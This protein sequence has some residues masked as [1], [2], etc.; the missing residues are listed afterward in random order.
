MVLR[1]GFKRLISLLLIVMMLLTTW[2]YAIPGKEVSA[3]KAKAVPQLNKKS[4]NVLVKKS[5][6]LKLKKK[7][8]GAKIRWKSNKKKVAKVNKK[9]KVT[10]RKKGT[11]QITATVTIKGKRRKL[12][13]KVNVIQKANSIA[14]TYNNG[15]TGKNISLKQGNVLSL[16]VR[17]NP[18]NSNDIISSW[19]SSNSNAVR[20]D[21][22]GKITA[23]KQG[24]AVITAT[25]FGKARATVNVSVLSD[26][27]NNVLPTEVVPT[28]ETPAVPPIETTEPPA[29]SPTITPMGTTEEPPTETPSGTTKEP[30]TET[31]SGT[32]EE[33]ATETPGINETTAEIMVVNDV[34]DSFLELITFGIFHDD[35]QEVQITAESPV[36]IKK[37]EYCITDQD[38]EIGQMDTL[39]FIEYDNNDRPILQKG[40]QNIV[41]AKITDNND[42]VTYIR[43]DGIEI[44]ADGGETSQP[45]ATPGVIATATPGTQASATPGVIST[46]TPTATPGTPGILPLDLTN[47]NNYFAVSGEDT[48]QPNATASW[49]VET[50]AVDVKTHFYHQGIGFKFELPAGKTLADYESFEYD[51]QFS[52]NYLVY[53]KDL[54][55]DVSTTQPITITGEN[56]ADA[57][58][59]TREGQYNEEGSSAGG[60]TA[61]GE[62]RWFTNQTIP[63]D[64]SKHA[65]KSGTIYIAMGLHCGAT[66]GGNA[67]YVKNVRLKEKADSSNDLVVDLTNAG[68]YSEVGDG[69]TAAW[70]SAD[71]GVRAA[72]VDYKQGITF[73]FNI[74]QGK[75]L[76][77]YES[78]LYDIKFDSRYL[79]YYKTL[80]ADVSSSV[81][82]EVT[83]LDVS[84][85]TL[86]V[87]E[88]P[89]NE[90]GSSAAGTEATDIRLWFSNQA[91]PIDAV[92]HAN[93]TG[94]V[95]ITI[96]LHCGPTDGGNAFFVK[97]VRLKAKAEGPVTPPTATPT[98]APTATPVVVPTATPSTQT[99]ATPKVT[100]TATPTATPKI[101]ATL[102]PVQRTT[103]VDFEQYEL[104]KTLG[105]TEGNAS[106]TVK[107]SADPSNTGQKSLQ[108]NSTGHNQAAIVPIFLPYEV[109]SYQTFKFRFRLSSGTM[110]RNKEFSLYISNDTSNFVKYGFG[111][112]TTEQ[113]SF[114]PYLVGKVSAEITAEHQNKWT[115]FTIN[116]SG[117]SD[118]IKDMRGDLFM[119]I[120]AHDSEAMGYLI[121]DLSFDLISSINPTQVPLPTL[122]PSNPPAPTPVPEGQGAARIS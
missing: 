112:P 21:S 72:T 25:M 87:R 22:K 36:G 51:I 5:V 111:N 27:G 41:Y 8:K 84:S 122:R 67:Y 39:T 103:T 33:P 108:I 12:T 40:T 86:G 96:G 99:S 59:G 90:A 61:T 18:S 106:P 121:D 105:F 30:P 20:V 104:D 23:V 37:I 95:Y 98:A 110:P 46:A 56:I 62:R 15:K 118:T 102:P 78:F 93:V 1:K 66:D 119:A 58:L 53:Y 97:N 10:G 76:A 88:N 107:I 100:P 71:N 80:R 109:K 73:K 68:N 74:P 35:E 101:P 52:S 117:L 47:S 85:A 48:S 64:G 79:V 31:P 42:T 69:A 75:T 92:K 83:D 57:T 81:P 7:I 9:G 77:D 2:M 6:K 4:V 113:Y 16:S 32:T 114:V 3:A 14:I 38:V 50:S 45:S 49:S 26:G 44:R 29:E 43:S 115:E 60:T 55:A 89:Y 120:G 63:I 70:N 94:T 34:W 28:T 82:A 17:K 116:I 11:A 24:R 91:I 13:C 19:K 65:D 54:R